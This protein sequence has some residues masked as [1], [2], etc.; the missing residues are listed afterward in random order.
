MEDSLVEALSGAIATLISTVIFYP[1]DLAKTRLQADPNG[2]TIFEA[3]KQTLAS[4][5]A[6]AGLGLTAFKQSLASAIF[7]FWYSALQAK[8]EQLQASWRRRSP[9]LGFVVSLLHGTIA[10]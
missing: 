7:N 5:S 10:G 6:F 2:G 3:L 9:A 4:D 1:Y 8:M